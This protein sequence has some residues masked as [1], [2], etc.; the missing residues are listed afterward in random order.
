M[1]KVDGTMMQIGEKQKNWAGLMINLIIIFGK[2][3]R[4]FVSILSSISHYSNG[5][6]FNISEFT[7]LFGDKIFMQFTYFNFSEFKD[8]INYD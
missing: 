5:L 1:D 4:K 3:T 6:G 8:H 2:W 7:S